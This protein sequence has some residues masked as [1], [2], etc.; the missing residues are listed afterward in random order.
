MRCF[1]GRGTEDPELISD[2]SDLGGKQAQN[3]L[4]GSNSIGSKRATMYYPRPLALLHL[5]PT[6][7]MIWSARGPLRRSTCGALCTFS[8]LMAH[9]P[10]GEAF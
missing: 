7:G 2:V 5:P 1:S 10:R 4:L 9:G 3:L 6:A 8:L